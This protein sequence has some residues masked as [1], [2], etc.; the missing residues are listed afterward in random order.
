[1]AGDDVPNK[2]PDPSIYLIAAE[3]MGVD[4]SECLVIEDSTIGVKVRRWLCF[5]GQYELCT[6]ALVDWANC[7]W[8]ISLT[9]GIGVAHFPTACF[10]CAI[11]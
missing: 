3:R 1:M 8:S 4:P 7:C 6:D 11:M 2:K 10:I 9:P 5:Q